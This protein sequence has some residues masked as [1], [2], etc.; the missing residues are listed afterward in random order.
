MSNPVKAQRFMSPPS[1]VV[2]IEIPICDVRF[3]QRYL[4]P[5]SRVVWIEILRV[6]LPFSARVVTTLAG[7]VD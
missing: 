3:C 4:S 5:P 7:G 2:W 1:R 6:M